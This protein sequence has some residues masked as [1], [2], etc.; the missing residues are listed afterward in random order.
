VTVNAK[1]QEVFNPS[2]VLKLPL[3]TVSSEAVYIE[4]VYIVEMRLSR[5]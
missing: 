5:R 1:G 4:A 3:S 2:N